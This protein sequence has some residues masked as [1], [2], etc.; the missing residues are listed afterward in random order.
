[1]IGVIEMPVYNNAL[2]SDFANV[3]DVFDAGTIQLLA[4]DD[5]VLASNALPADAWAA[6]VNGVKQKEGV[7]QCVGNANAGVGVQCTQVVLS[8]N[9][10]TMT[11]VATGPGGGGEA[12]ITNDAT[13]VDH[14][15]I[16][17]D[18]IVT[19][20]TATYTHPSGE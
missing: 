15:I 16:V 8:G 1:M 19:V 17:E 14:D 7:W 10:R 9:G 18:A 4:A 5:T 11:L 13:G 6:A 20:V 2:R 3:L 12:I